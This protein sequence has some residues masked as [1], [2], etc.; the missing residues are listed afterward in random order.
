MRF[1]FFAVLSGLAALAV[2]NVSGL[3]VENLQRDV[4]SDSEDVSKRSDDGCRCK[5]DFSLNKQHKFTVMT[6]HCY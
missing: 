2:I 6:G 4:P 5:F 3:P 1:Y